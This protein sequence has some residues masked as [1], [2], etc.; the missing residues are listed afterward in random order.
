MEYLGWIL[1]LVTLLISSIIASKQDKSIKELENI[2]EKKD[3]VIDSYR[4]INDNLRRDLD[5]I[6]GA[7]VSTPSDCKIGEWCGACKFRKS[8]NVHPNRRG[9]YEDIHICGKDGICKNF[10]SA[11]EEE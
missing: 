10:V 2:I 3:E 7:I 5:M 11:N 6:K 4:N 9:Y 8:F 1:L